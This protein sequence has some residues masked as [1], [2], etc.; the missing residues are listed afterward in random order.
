MVKLPPVVVVL[1]ISGFAGSTML[2]SLFPVLD[3]AI[4][5]VNVLPE[6]VNVIGAAPALKLEV[7]VTLNAFVCVMAPLPAEVST[8][9]FPPIVEL[10]NCNAP[11]LVN[12]TLFAPELLK[13]TA[14]I[15]TFAEF[16]VIALAPALKLDVPGTVRMPVWV[17][18]PL[19]EIVKF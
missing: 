11:L 7:P 4:P 12:E 3:E 1:T 6:L 13:V 18:A 14:P 17:I 8:V 2:M 19:D 9:K 15:N 10:A 16:K 5:P